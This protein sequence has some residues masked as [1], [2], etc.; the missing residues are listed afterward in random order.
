MEPGRVSTVVTKQ[1]AGLG[2]SSVRVGRQT[3]AETV[4]GHYD[5]W[6]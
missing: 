2:G 5:V 1:F 3:V 6:V 4:R